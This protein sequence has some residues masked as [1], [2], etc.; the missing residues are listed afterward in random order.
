MCFALSYAEQERS[1]FRYSYSAYQIEYS[2]NLLFR[3]G[4][5]MERV[6]QGFIDRTRCHLGMRTVKTLF[7]RRHRPYCTRRQKNPRFEVVVERPEYHLTIFKLRCGR[8]GLKIYT[9]GERVLRIEATAHNTEDLRCGRVVE[10]FPELVAA[11][12]EM[13]KRFLEVLQCLDVTWAAA[14]AP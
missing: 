14:A 2:R 13:V 5:E 9:K 7:G 3:R 6:F 8:L 10:K 1:R 12:A 11:L 4:S